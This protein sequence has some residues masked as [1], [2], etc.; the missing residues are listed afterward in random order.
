MLIFLPILAYV[1]FSLIPIGNSFLNI[2]KLP[3]YTNF[4]TFPST[5][6]THVNNNSLN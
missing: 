5:P 4:M 2:S 6:I 3:L 1:A